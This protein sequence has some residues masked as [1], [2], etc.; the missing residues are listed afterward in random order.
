MERQKDGQMQTQPKKI[1]GSKPIP[2]IPLRFREAIA[3]VRKV[4]P[5]EK[6][7]KTKAQP[8]HKTQ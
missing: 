4:M 2:H 5:Q 1:T 8:K 3:D 6:T 7:T